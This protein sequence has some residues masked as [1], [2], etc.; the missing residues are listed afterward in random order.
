MTF[1]FSEKMPPWLSGLVQH[2]DPEIVTSL[3]PSPLPPQ[4]VVSKVKEQTEDVQKPEGKR[5]QIVEENTPSVL[6]LLKNK[7]SLQSSI[8][9]LIR[10]LAK[11]KQDIQQAAITL[12]HDQHN[13]DLL[14]KVT[15]TQYLFTLC[16]R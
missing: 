13:S 11:K 2:K 16:T 3:A 4:V 7:E 8:L 14:I 12:I 6:S 1:C 5:N 15:E 9:E 10:E